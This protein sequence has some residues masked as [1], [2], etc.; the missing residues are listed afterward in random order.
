MVT[1]VWFGVGFAAGA[2]AFAHRHEIGRALAKGI[3]RRRNHD[4]DDDNTVPSRVF[5]PN[6]VRAVGS[7]AFSWC[8]GLVWASVPMDCRLGPRAFPSRTTMIRRVPDELR[9]ILREGT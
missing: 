4:D 6:G 2:R 8:R 9:G 7:G 3:G 1:G 5:I